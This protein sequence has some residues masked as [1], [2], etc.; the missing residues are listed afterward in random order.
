[1]TE[2][3]WTRVEGMIIA[4]A[5]DPQEVAEELASR[6]ILAQL[7]WFRRSPQLLGIIVSVQDGAVAEV[8]SD[9][10]EPH[11]GTALVDLT[12]EL[13]VLFDA[14]V[15]LGS[16][17][18]DHLPEG[19]SPLADA[20]PET[21]ASATSRV[22]EIGRTPASS[23]P[24]LAALE[25]VD[26]ADEEL[27]DGQRVLL[28]ELP[29]ERVGWNF[30]DVPLVSLSVTEGEFQ[31]FLVTDDDPEN[32]VSHNWGMQTL[33]VP[34]AYADADSLSAEVVGLVGDRDDLVAIATQVPGA[35][36][37][38][39]V[40]AAQLEGVEAVH[41]AVSA[42]G[43]ERGIAGFLT[44]ETPLAGVQGAE[45]H[46]ARGISN[47]IGRS[48]D[49]MLTEPDS[50]TFPIWDAYHTTAVERPWVVRIGASVEAAVG[51]TLLALAIRTEKPR[52]GWVRVG[53]I[54]GTLMVID[55]VAEVSLAKYL[56]IRDAR[57]NSD[58]S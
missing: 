49:I 42:L 41:A 19:E 11:A 3:G 36:P 45:V 8:S 46:L 30:G 29:P 18:A 28:A 6:G 10:A 50:P 31:A 1:M 12:E 25:G 33:L 51:A 27:P 17:A 15:R 5:L 57:Q 44:G 54:L 7:E 9:S 26:I 53:G 39:F 58:L 2:L 48:V 56:G 34:G 24:L 52:N 13:A 35:D 43:L 23:V 32:V 14:E 16:C 47:A 38:A 40:A 20:T 22:V 4:R 21:D 55:S 37:E